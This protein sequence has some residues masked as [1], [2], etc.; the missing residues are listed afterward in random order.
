MA[1]ILSRP[2]FVIRSYS[3]CTLRQQSHWHLPY[4][5][6]CKQGP[7]LLT[8]TVMPAWIDKHMPSKLWGEITSVAPLKFGNE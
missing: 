1:D 7:F 8:L 4:T 3:F 5:P 6:T 2:Q